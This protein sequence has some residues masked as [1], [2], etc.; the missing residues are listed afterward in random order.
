MMIKLKNDSE[1]RRNAFI[2]AVN[3]LKGAKSIIIDLRNNGGGKPNAVQLLCSLFMEEESQLDSILWRKG[4]SYTLQTWDTLPHKELP[5]EMRLL[6]QKVVILI[7][8][9][10]FSAAESFANS[11]QALG[12]ATIVGERSGGG[13]NPGG[14]EPIGQD[15][16]LR[17]PSG[18]AYK[19]KSRR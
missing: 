12:R 3:N 2:E 7:S 10:T 17:I 1:E 13:A 14:Y 4:N 11:M 18:R 19:S 6:E 5:K 16:D 9:K 8:P 15:F